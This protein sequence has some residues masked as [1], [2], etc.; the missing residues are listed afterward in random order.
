V[1]AARHAGAAAT[2]GRRLSRRD[3]PGRSGIVTAKEDSSDDAVQIA[4]CHVMQ[5]PP[6]RHLIPLTDPWRRVGLQPHQ[7]GD[8]AA[9]V[10]TPPQLLPRIPPTAADIA[11]LHATLQKRPLYTKNMLAPN[12]KGAESPFPPPSPT[13]STPG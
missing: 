1:L 11:A 3:A 4:N 9:D 7:H 2:R 8:I 5:T 12:G 10:V 13:P 6:R